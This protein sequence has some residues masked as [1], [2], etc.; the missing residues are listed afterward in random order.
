MLVREKYKHTHTHTHTHTHRLRIT[1]SSLPF[2]LSLIIPD[3]YLFLDSSPASRPC[4]M[5]RTSPQ[6]SLY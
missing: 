4:T 1:F 3:V 5:N 6:D 2:F